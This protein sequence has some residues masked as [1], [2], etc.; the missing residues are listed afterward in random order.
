MR[1]LHYSESS[2]SCFRAWEVLASC[3]FS[4]ELRSL[5]EDGAVDLELCRGSGISSLA[6]ERAPLPD[7]GPPLL[8]VAIKQRLK[9]SFSY[10][11][12]IQYVLPAICFLTC[13][14]SGPDFGI[15][16]GFPP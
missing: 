12:G 2:C 10:L 8:A 3:A 6:E 11:L 9:Y 5:L 15:A 1:L 16:F 7:G 14:E 13:G 4:V